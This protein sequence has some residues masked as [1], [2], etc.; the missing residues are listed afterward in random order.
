[1]STSG[2]MRV[3]FPEFSV[4]SG[5]YLFSLERASSSAPV[6]IDALYRTKDKSVRWLSIGEIDKTENGGWKRTF[7]IPEEAQSIRIRVEFPVPGSYIVGPSIQTVAQS[8]LQEG[9]VTLSFDDGYKS[10]VDV[11]API[12][13]EYKYS[14]S[15]PV[16]TSHTV[17]PGYLQ[18]ADLR[19]IL[20]MGH[21]VVSHTRN[22]ASL[23]ETMSDRL[24]RDEIMG[25]RHDL[26]VQG[27]S[28]HAFVYP[29]GAYSSKSE[30]YVRS[31][32]YLGARTV[33]RGYNSRNSDPFLLR[34]QF[35]NASSTRSDMRAILDVAQ[36]EKLW[37][38]LELHDVL[39]GSAQSN[40]DI[41]TTQLR[42]LLEEIQSTGLKVVTLGEGVRILQSR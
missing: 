13:S 15:V 32:G 41:T 11:V 23:D 19:S 37:V 14:A 5:D 16:I 7:R 17:K 10:F 3:E 39:P 34:D 22:H 33:E 21:E 40:G 28:A 20:S 27:I 18:L 24:L 38:I 2:P 35:I 9:L 12:L 4:S 29:F 1:M 25:S 30:E 6:K 36:K 31:A 8:Q 42:E 26:F